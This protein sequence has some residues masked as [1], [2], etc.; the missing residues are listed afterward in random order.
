MIL[1]IIRS[2][3]ILPVTIVHPHLDTVLAWIGWKL[4]VW[5]SEPINSCFVWPVNEF[6]FWIKLFGAFDQ[7]SLVLYETK[8]PY[9][10]VGRTIE[11]FETAQNSRAVPIALAAQTPA[12]DKTTPDRNNRTPSQRIHRGHQMTIGK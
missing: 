9:Y 8:F 11:K 7:Y 3:E 10:G 12:K 5:N 6:L 4:F 2:R 1:I